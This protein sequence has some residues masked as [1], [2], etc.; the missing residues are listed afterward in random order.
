M[1]SIQVTFLSILQTNVDFGLGFWEIAVFCNLATCTYNLCMYFHKIFLDLISRL[2][3]YAN[4]IMKCDSLSRKLFL[5][6]SYRVVRSLFLNILL[7][8][9]WTYAK[10]RNTYMHENF[11]NFT[12]IKSKKYMRVNHLH[13]TTVHFVK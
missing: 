2:G 6:N 9:C 13:L 4:I 3:Y 12:F 8:N 5:R 7:S 10:C 1:I 11:N